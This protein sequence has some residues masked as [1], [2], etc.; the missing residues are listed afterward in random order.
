MNTAF[1][2]DPDRP[3]SVPEVSRLVKDAL[4]GRFPRLSVQGEVLRFTRAASGHA[5][6]SLADQDVGGSPH[7]LQCVAYKSARAAASKILVDGQQIVATGRL[8]SWG[9][10]SS[11]QLVVD[12][13]EEAGRGDLLRRLEALKAKL[14]AEGLFDSARK[15]P[16]PALPRCV[17]VV[18]SLRG[19]AVKDIVRTILSRYPMHIL[20]V[21][22]V[23]QGD[24]AAA[25][26]AA[27]IAL[28]NRVH[29]V[30]VIIIGR[31]GGS[32]EDLWAFNEEALVRA[33]AAS[34]VPVVSAVG[35]EIDHVLTD[36]VADARAPTPTAA[37]QMVVPAIEDL[38]AHLHGVTQ[39]RDLAIDARLDRAGQQLDQ[40]VMRHQRLAAR[41]NTEPRHRLQVLA[42][43]LAGR[44]PRVVLQQHRQ[45]IVECSTRLRTAASHL[46]DRPVRALEALRLRLAPLDPYAPLDRGYALARTVDGLVVNRFDQVSPGDEL[47]LWIREG[48][49]TARVETTRAER[50]R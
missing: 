24:T 3:L 10:S 43:R 12:T 18:T 16:L 41:I 7:R 5:Y 42:A 37:G 11:Y 21:D 4:E 17:G 6:F 30:D 2:F 14:L 15:R 25:Q 22:A 50:Q 48:S 29:N 34:R 23:V 38:R 32:M 36:D 26:V 47:D 45:S 46:S 44:H 35:H 33:V 8:T 1:P 20:L 31:G 40:L 19:A 13:I 9:G 28:L 27:G 39:R 49:V